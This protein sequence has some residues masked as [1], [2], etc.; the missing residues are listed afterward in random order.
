VE[1]PATAAEIAECATFFSNAAKRGSSNNGAS[2]KKKRG[3]LTRAERSSHARSS[4][5]N[6]LSL[7]PSAA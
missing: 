6:A 2:Q 4:A 7:S 3:E 1:L 5:A